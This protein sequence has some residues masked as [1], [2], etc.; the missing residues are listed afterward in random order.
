M[1]YLH[2]HIILLQSNH[3]YDS[4]S[5]VHWF[6]APCCPVCGDQW[7]GI[8]GWWVVGGLGEKGLACAPIGQHQP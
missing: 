2:P 3:S 4:Y 8:R 5:L 1:A 7:V 6:W